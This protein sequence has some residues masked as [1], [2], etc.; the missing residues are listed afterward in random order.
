M[1]HSMRVS[2]NIIKLISGRLIYENGDVWEGEWRDDKAN[3]S[4]EN[5]K[6]NIN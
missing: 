5:S 1:N 6:S 2:R 4:I 3:E